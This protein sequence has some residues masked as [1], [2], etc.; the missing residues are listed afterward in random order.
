[1]KKV[2]VTGDFNIPADLVKNYHLS[3]IRNLNGLEELEAEMPD[4]WGYVLG[5]PEFLDA[6]LLGLAPQLRRIVV[7]GTGIPSFVDIEAGQALGIQIFNTPQVN[8][9]SVAEFAVGAMI[10]SLARAFRSHAGLLSGSEWYQG[11]R[12]GLS[13]AKVFL[14]GIGNIGEELCA[15]LDGLGVRGISYYSRTR[16]PKLEK[17]YDLTFLPLAEGLA[18]A[19]V[20][21]IQVAYNRGTHGLINRDSLRSANPN[22]CLLNV[23]NPKVVVAP[24]LR[25]WLEENENAHAY[26][27]GFY[28]EW[29]ANRGASDDPT[30]LL[31]L[32]PHKF[33]A[34]SHIAAQERKTVQRLLRIAFDKLASDLEG[35]GE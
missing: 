5:G 16:K 32:S 24:H 29:L 9:A 26:M 11:Q 12:I 34:T 13:E 15:R 30:G 33:T 6:R 4:A 1:M 28:Q 21:S 31:K 20:A 2:L 25:Q 17:A 27:D 8:A 23:S 19:D 14:I 18:R 3:H 10:M 22:L 7:L 35:V